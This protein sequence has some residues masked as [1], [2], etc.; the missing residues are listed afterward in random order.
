ME[1]SIGSSR[2]DKKRLLSL[3]STIQPQI[4]NLPH[5]SLAGLPLHPSRPKTPQGNDIRARGV[6]EVGRGAGRGEGAPRTEGWLRWQH[7]SPRG[8]PSSLTAAT[9]YA[10]NTDG[11]PG[12]LGG[13]GVYLDL[14]PTSPQL[15]LLPSYPARGSP[16]AGCLGPRRGGLDCGPPGPS[17]ASAL[18][19]PT[20]VARG[21]GDSCAWKPEPWAT[22]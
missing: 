1:H 15:P 10:S 12:L 3:C 4:E 14:L 7:P 2:R 16:P 6:H 21:P 13:G 20:G 17:T 22:P 19:C 11:G 9:P 8:H 18:L 5:A